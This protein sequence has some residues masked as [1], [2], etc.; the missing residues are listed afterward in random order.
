[1]L[2]GKE[3][4]RVRVFVGVDQEDTLRRFMI[5]PGTIVPEAASEYD[6]GAR[7]PRPTWRVL[8][9]GE[10]PKYT[11]RGGK[12]LRGRSLYFG[13]LTDEALSYIR[14]TDLE[15]ARLDIRQPE[16]GI[17]VK[18][19]IKALRT[20]VSFSGQLTYLGASEDP[21]GAP[22]VSLDPCSGLAV[23]LHVDNWDKLPLEKR[24]DGLNR[25]AINI[26]N[27][28]RSFLFLPFRAAR[29]REAV[30][31]RHQV[32]GVS[33]PNG[34]QFMAAYPDFPVLRYV[35]APGHYYVAPT[36]NI[37]HDGCTSGAGEGSRSLVLRGNIS[38]NGVESDS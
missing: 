15:L 8:C 3:S 34:R 35:L 21:Q 18:G 36:E 32:F 13:K 20:F 14:R 1:M 30:E 5:S 26:G 19:V 6:S 33:G 2:M 38:P 37:V 9:P 24:D 4:T 22:T 16:F 12:W 29:M 31:Q 17:L 10:L 23:G 7:I 11:D 27:A 25:I 28:C